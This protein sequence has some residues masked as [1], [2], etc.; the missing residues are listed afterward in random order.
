MAIGTR[1]LPRRIR[2]PDSLE[3][4]EA[5]I[6]YLRIYINGSRTDKTETWFKVENF[7]EEQ[8]AFSNLFC[9]GLERL[10]RNDRPLQAFEDINRAFDQLKQMVMR[11][12]PLVCIK[13]MIAAA[14]FARFPKS[15]ICWQI[16]RLLFDHIRKLTLIIH[17]PNHPLNHIWNDTLRL[18]SGSDPG[19]LVLGVA[20]NGIQR[21]TAT[22]SSHASG[23]LDIADRVPG[24]TRGLDEASLREN[25]KMM[26]ASPAL[27][28]QA[29]ETRLALSELLLKKGRVLEGSQFY[30]EAIGFM[31]DDPLHHTDTFRDKE[32]LQ[33]QVLIY[34]KSLSDFFLEFPSLNK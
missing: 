2:A 12:H 31:E 30:Y 7:F 3:K 1:T 22:R 16:C 5:A 11:D 21:R 20:V 4:V 17:G 27:L 32:G 6:Y 8:G 28:P 23:A 25:L 10:S 15:E 29:Q 26:A 14:T 18:A 19:S 9:K 33:F 24:S 34:G 13:L